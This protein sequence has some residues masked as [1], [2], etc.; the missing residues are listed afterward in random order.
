M[1]SVIAVEHELNTLNLSTLIGSWGSSPQEIIS[2][3]RLRRKQEKG[4]V[5]AVMSG[6]GGAVA[7]T[8]RAPS[9]Y[10]HQGI[11]DSELHSHQELDIIML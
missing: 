7:G 11:L 3:L 9:Y 4:G 6:A 2:K 5:E 8:T 10:S 1:R